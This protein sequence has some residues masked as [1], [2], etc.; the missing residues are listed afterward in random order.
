MEI[1]WDLILKSTF[2]GDSINFEGPTDF[3]AQ[4]VK[5]IFYNQGSSLA[6]ANLVK[7]KDGYS[8]QDMLDTF[9]GGLYFG[10]HDPNNVT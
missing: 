4:P 3:K 8:H 1:S 2:Y 10:H 6:A 7:H 9:E 5:L